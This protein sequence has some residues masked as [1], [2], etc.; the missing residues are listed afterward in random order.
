MLLAELVC[1]AM[2]TG[3]IW[4]IQIVHYPSFD[5]VP[6]AR[7]KIFHQFHSQRITWIVLPLMAS[8]L[9]MAAILAWRTHFTLPLGLNLLGV[10]A[11]WSFTALLSVPLHSRL[12]EAYQPLDVLRLVQTNWPRTILWTVRTVGL[13]YLCWRV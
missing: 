12:G 13:F 11:I 8:E 1:C 7:F 4:V 9:V 5:F 10:L 3:V 6:E 2:M